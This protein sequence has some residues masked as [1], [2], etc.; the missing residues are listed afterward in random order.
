MGPLVR[1]ARGR[2]GWSRQ[3]L[4][5]QIPVDVA[6]LSRW[7]SGTRPIPVATVARLAILLDAPELLTAACAVCPVGAACDR[8]ATEEVA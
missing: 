1:A 5:L 2:R 3:K 6:H 7:E 8:A 4:A